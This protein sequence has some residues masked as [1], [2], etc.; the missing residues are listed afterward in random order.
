MRDFFSSLVERFQEADR[1]QRL[2]V[3]LAVVVAIVGLRYGVSWL[4]EYRDQ[5]KADIRLSAQ[6][7]AGAR[8]LVEREG[9]AQEHLLSLIHISE[10]TRPY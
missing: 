1:Q 5:V 8:K 10:P 4:F 6:R 2:Y 9:E 7:L 3:L